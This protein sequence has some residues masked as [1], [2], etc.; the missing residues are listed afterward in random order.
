[1]HFKYEVRAIGKNK[2]S[3]EPETVLI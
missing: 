1:M 3:G 2:L